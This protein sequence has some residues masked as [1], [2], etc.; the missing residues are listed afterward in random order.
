MF[1]ST[2]KRLNQIRLYFSLMQIVG[3][4]GEVSSVTM[5]SVCDV[6]QVHVEVYIVLV[7][8]KNVCE[9]TNLFS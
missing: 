1:P 2:S 3:V 4:N 5:C 8:F 6:K 7:L 9:D